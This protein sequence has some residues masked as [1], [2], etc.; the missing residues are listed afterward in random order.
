MCKI[1]GCQ[2]GRVW[3][4]AVSDGLKSGAI[5]GWESLGTG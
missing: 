4:G 3:V 2:R 5:M 1:I